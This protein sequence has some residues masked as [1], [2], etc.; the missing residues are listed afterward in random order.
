MSKILFAWIGQTDLNASQSD[1]KNG[2]GPI[3]QAVAEGAYEEIALL[4]NYPKDKGI[5]Y[6]KW[7]GYRTTAKITIANVS[8]N[9]P[10][11]LEGI[12]EA[13]SRIVSQ[14]KEE[15]KDDIKIT[16][17]TSPGTP[18]MAVI[19]ILLSA[20]RYQAE[21]IKSSPQRGVSNYNLPFNIAADYIPEILKERDREIAKLASGGLA[22]PSAFN[23]IIYKSTVMQR[24]IQKAQ[25]VA[26]RSVPVLIEGASGTGKELLAR[27]IHYSGPRKGK[28]LIIVNCGAISPELLEAELFGHSKGSF[29]GAN[30]DR[31]GYFEE[32]HEGTLFLDELGEMPLKAQ[33]KLL[34]AVQE[35]EVLPVGASQSR[36]VDVR[37]IAATNRNL[38]QEVRKGNFREDLFYRLAVGVIKLPSLKERE[39]DI[40]LLI[41]RLLD[42]VNTEHSRDQA[43]ENKIFSVNAKKLL[44]NHS[45]PGNIRELLNTLHRAALWSSGKVI[46]ETD[47]AEA[48][49][50]TEFIQPTA[51]KYKPIGS[52]IDI[53]K[54]ISETAAH[55]LSEA[56]DLSGNNKTK[57]AELL[58]LNS[59]QTLTNWMKKHNIK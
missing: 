16:F 34:R 11:D 33:V 35:G 21:L 22:G 32:A 54:V 45:W 4:C 13:A 55:Y 52:G 2:A 14:K 38:L 20:S 57:A 8:L 39:G 19:W 36:K 48:L 58:G 53:N 50:P 25:R 6:Q 12:F 59:Y 43:Y 26:L 44:L 47:I 46:T 31:K 17:H 30:Q 18:Q 3:A 41:D 49:F 24:A 51:H 28:N 42:Q 23:D 15:H 1:G 40:E 9:D 27:A 5:S 37:I 7:L 56:L 10:T 29:T